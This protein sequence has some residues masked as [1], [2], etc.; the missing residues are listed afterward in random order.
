MTRVSVASCDPS[1][2]HTTKTLL[3]FRCASVTFAAHFIR[4]LR[5]QEMLNIWNGTGSGMDSCSWFWLFALL[6][7]PPFPFISSQPLRARLEELRMFLE[8]ETWELCPVKSNFNIAQLHVSKSHITEE[9]ERSTPAFIY[10]TLSLITHPRHL[11]ICIRIW[12][13]GNPDQWCL[14]VWVWVCLCASLRIN[15]RGGK[16][17]E[18]YITQKKITRLFSRVACMFEDCISHT[19]EQQLKI[20]PLNITT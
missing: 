3:P 13:A 5:T 7:H 14:C 9:R 1:H 20:K 10:S 17:I 11:D 16:L 15:M 4:A 6:C 2:A 19:D 12:S 18:S 8:N